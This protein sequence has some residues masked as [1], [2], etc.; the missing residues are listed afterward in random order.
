MVLEQHYQVL[1][2]VIDEHPVQVDGLYVN[3]FHQGVRR[4]EFPEVSQ[5]R[6]VE[7]LLFLYVLLIIELKQLG[8]THML[9]YL[10]F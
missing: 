3:S 1:S 5:L 10:V 9:E 7:L 4:R 2:V 8:F 6:V